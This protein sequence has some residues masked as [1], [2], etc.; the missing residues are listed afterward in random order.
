MRGRVS[1]VR[2]ALA[3]A[4]LPPLKGH[5]SVESLDPPSRRRGNLCWMRCDG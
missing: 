1:R 5:W 3:S 2:Q 4:A